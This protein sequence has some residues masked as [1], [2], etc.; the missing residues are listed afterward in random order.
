MAADA[1]AADAAISVCE[2]VPTTATATNL[3]SYLF[4]GGSFQSYGCA[5]IDPTFWLAGSGNSAT[6][7]FVATQANPS[8]RVWGMNTDDTASVQV[9]GASYP[10]TLSSASYADKVVCGLSPGPDGVLF[11][12]GN[13]IGANSPSLGNYSYQDVTLNTTGVTSITITGLTGAGWGIAGATAC[14]NGGVD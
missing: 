11:A 7:T 3:L 13:L 8:F 2:Y 12:D 6:I 1:Q 10:L 14:T 4:A 5:P 9:N